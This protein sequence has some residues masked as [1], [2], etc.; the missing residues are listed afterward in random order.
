MEASKKPHVVCMPAAAQGHITPMLKLAKILHTRGFHVTF[1][2]TEFNQRRLLE[3]RGPAAL[4]GLPDF[5]FA[6]MWDGL[7]T[8]DADAHQNLPELCY[9]VM[10]TC[11]P[12]F[13][14]LLAKLNVPGS[15]VPPVTCIIA[16]S[17]MSF[18]YDAAKEI[19]V[20][21]AALWTSSAC[22]FMGYRHSRQLIEQ[23]FVPFKDEAQVTDKGHL[24]TVVHG[25]RGMC[26]GMRLR[27][28][29]SFIRTTD[30]ED[31]LLNFVMAMAERL[32]LPN[33]VVLNTFDEIEGPVLDAMRDILPPMYTVGPLH[34]YASL[35]VPAGTTV[36]G[37]GSNLWKEEDDGLLEWLD[38]HGASSVVYVNYGSITVMT[39]EELL[40][41]AWGLAGSGYP[42]VW[43]IRPDLVRGDTAVLPPEFMS[44]V[45]DRSMLTTWCAQEKVIAHEAVGVFLTHSGWNSTLESICAG[46][47]MLSWPFFSE[48]QTNCRYKCTEWGIA[49]EIGGEVKRVELAQMIQEAMEGE[50]GHQMRKRS[51]EWKEKAVR[52]TLPGGPAEANLDAVI[53]DVLLARFNSPNDEK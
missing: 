44:S 18:A 11:L 43:N 14:A 5:R 45:G 28:F 24:D 2:N 21:C 1:V 32:S 48:Q 7:S 13:M 23:G 30:R 25:F 50:K 40:E 29:H 15:G 38:G 26:E 10:N 36:D 8:P 37:L 47:P 52:A 27:D 49:M 35:V 9:A 33:A 3:T 22:G 17:V 4:D 6:A 31:A 16:D 34:R 51:A 41:F 39:N 53:S 12:Q 19:G 42:F 46:V 20:P